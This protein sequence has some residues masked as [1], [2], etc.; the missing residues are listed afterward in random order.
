MFCLYPQRTFT[1]SLRNVFPTANLTWF[2]EGG[3]PQGE[4]E[5]KEISQPKWVWQKKKENK[6]E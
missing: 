4:K 5:G 6:E 2:I 1:C 3:F